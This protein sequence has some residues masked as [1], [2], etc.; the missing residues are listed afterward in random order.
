MLLLLSVALLCGISVVGY[1]LIALLDRRGDG[2]R[3]VLLAPGVGIAAVQMACYLPNRAGLPVQSFAWPLTGFLLA[4]ALAV[5]VLRRPA[6]PI[7]RVV[8]F[9]VIG[10]LALGLAGWPLVTVGPN[11]M[12]SLNED[13]SNYILLAERLRTQGYLQPPDPQVWAEQTDWSIH[14]WSFQALG[15]RSGTE[16]LLAWTASLSGLSTLQS[17]MPL[18]LTLHVSLIATAAGLV[19]RRFGAPARI[20]SA[21]LLACSA[22]LVLGVQ[23]QVIAQILGLV[24]LA[25]LCGLC[26]APIDRPPGRAIWRLV[27]LAGLVSGAFVL[28]YPE[29]LPFFGLPFLLYHLIRVWKGEA[30]PYRLV[31][32]SAAIAVVAGLLVLPELPGISVFFL[33]QLGHASASTVTDI[34]PYMLLPSGF[35]ALW[36]WTAFAPLGVS[37]AKLSLLISL[38]FALSVFLL[39]SA[40]RLAWRETAA[41]VVTL[42]MSLTMIGLVAQSVGFASFKLAMYVQPFLLPTLVMALTPGGWRARR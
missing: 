4:A 10:V 28:A 3:R 11:W 42:V 6:L 38:G 25:T 39:V 30:R 16:L 9:V 37:E 14:F 40:A 36:G 41:A 34:F 35:A 13:M 2:V 33:G 8:P 12:A 31:G 27:P 26:L 7:R 32:V 17:F 21:F 19:E 22:P 23:L 5:L 15:M 29:L 18:A 20:L 1:A 24:L